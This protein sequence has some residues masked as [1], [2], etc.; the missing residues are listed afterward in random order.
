MLLAQRLD[1]ADTRPS[2]VIV[3]WIPQDIGELNETDDWLTGD[4]DIAVRLPC[5]MLGRKMA[6]RRRQEFVQRNDLLNKQSSKRKWIQ[7]LAIVSFV[8]Q[9]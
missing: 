1:A 7:K 3:S 4:Y 6:T 5:N 8:E 9:K 2:H